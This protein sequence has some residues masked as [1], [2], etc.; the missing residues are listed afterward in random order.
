MVRQSVLASESLP[1][2]AERHY[3]PISLVDK[4]SPPAKRKTAKKKAHKGKKYFA[5]RTELK[6]NQE[7]TKQKNLHNQNT[8][9][10]PGPMSMCCT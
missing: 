6:F 9:S 10:N 8:D 5:I 2:L 7:S 3:P 1:P 4:K